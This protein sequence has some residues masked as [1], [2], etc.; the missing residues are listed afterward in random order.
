VPN[1]STQG[2]V[3]VLNG[4]VTFFH[5]RKKYGFIEVDDQEDDIFFHVSN[6]EGDEISEGTD[7][8]FET[9]EGEK[10]LEAV[11]VTEA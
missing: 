4:T 6:L 10:G 3:L 8:E 9:E 5:E 11:N 7:V 1:T 2:G